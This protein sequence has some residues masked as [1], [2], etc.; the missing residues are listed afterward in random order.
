MEFL[1][2][3]ILELFLEI[4]G[5]IL[6]ELGWESVKKAFGLENQRPVW[7]AIGLSLLGAS[8]GCVSIWLFP[9]RL[10]RTRVPGVSLLLA[11]LLV[12]A[13][14]HA[15][16][17]YRRGRGH[18]PT[19]LATFWGGGIFAFSMAIVRFLGTR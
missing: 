12:G 1:F 3:V 19:N 2:Q 17:R 6:L 14:L 13:S 15:F 18:H 9:G 10:F 5:D 8:V 16:G 7:A 4:F 11:P